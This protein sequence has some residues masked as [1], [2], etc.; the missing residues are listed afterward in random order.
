MVINDE[1]VLIGIRWSGG[2]DSYVSK[3]ISQ[4]QV[5][6]DRI[7]MGYTVR[8]VDLSAYSQLQGVIE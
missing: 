1:L 6:V 2:S 4:I 3:Y 8:M 5:I 7:G